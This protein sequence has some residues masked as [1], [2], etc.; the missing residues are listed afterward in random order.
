MKMAL[1]AV[2]LIGAGLGLAFRESVAGTTAM[3]V[4]LGV[5]YLALGAL[6]LRRLYD[7]GTLRDVLRPRAGD[8]TIGFLI[9]GALYGGAWTLHHFV[10]RGGSPQILWLYRLAL[11]IGNAG[12][13]PSPTLFG[14]V[15]VFAVLEELVWRGLV[16]ST[17]SE[18]LG[19]RRAWPAA[20]VAYALAHVPT[21]IVLGDP[22]AGPNPV[23]VFAAFGCGLVWTF[24]TS[25]T[26]R[27]PP[28]MVSHAIFSYFA[29]A[30]LLPRF[31]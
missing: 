3:W 11:S 12:A 13:R 30:T 23:L 26:G 29:I 9:A 25:L 22:V 21:V 6:A 24:A 31:G 14:I 15:T 4:W 7:D 5:P 28:V 17:L 19:T 18:S 2:A 16:L 10:L 8:L 20:A 27:L 1:L